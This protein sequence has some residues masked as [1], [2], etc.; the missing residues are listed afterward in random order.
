MLQWTADP[1]DPG[2]Y[3]SDLYREF[4]QL[5]MMFLRVIPG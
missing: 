4:G 5:P 1:K 3:A 2:R